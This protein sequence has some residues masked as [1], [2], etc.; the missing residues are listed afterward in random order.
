MK[1]SVV[2][3][4]VSFG[5]LNNDFL[6]VRIAFASG[7]NRKRNKD[8]AD[9]FVIANIR[10]D[11]LLRAMP[12]PLRQNPDFEEM[13]RIEINEIYIPIF[14]SDFNFVGGSSIDI[15]AS[16]IFESAAFGF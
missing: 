9:F 6:F 1:D 2:D 14:A 15:F 10:L 3:R 12:D 5:L 8:A 11:F 4:H 16:E 7:L 13:V